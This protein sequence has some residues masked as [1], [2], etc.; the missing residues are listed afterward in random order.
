MIKIFLL[1]LLTFTLSAW[2]GP[3]PAGHSHD[4]AAIVTHAGKA[5]PRFSAGTDLFEVVGILSGGEL[6]VFVD[7]FAT[8]VPV[9]DAIVELESGAF[10]AKG[11]LHKD[12]GDFV[13]PADIFNKPGSHA[14]VLTIT[15]GEDIDIIAANLVVPDARAGDEHAAGSWLSKQNLLYAGGTLLLITIGAT[16]WRFK[17]GAKNKYGKVGGSH[18]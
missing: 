17:S 14:L 18:V 1:L 12:L 5:A 13:F 6:A 3:G 16:T 11:V 15:A 10:K 7:R 4:S 8:N 2:A 9:V